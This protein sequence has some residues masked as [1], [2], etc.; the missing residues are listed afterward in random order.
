M[1]VAVT[2]GTTGADEATIGTSTIADGVQITT[3]ALLETP[4]AAIATC[5]EAEEIVRL[6]IGGVERVAHELDRLANALFQE[7]AVFRAV[8]RAH[9]SLHVVDTLQIEPLNHRSDR[10]H[11]QEV[12]AVVITIDDE[13]RHG[14]R[15]ADLAGVRRRL[16]RGGD[17]LTPEAARLAAV[18]HVHCPPGLTDLA[19]LE[20]SQ[21]PVLVLVLVLGQ[22]LGHAHALLRD[23]PVEEM[24]EVRLLEMR[25]D[26]VAREELQRQRRDAGETVHQPQIDESHADGSKDGPPSYRHAKLTIGALVRLKA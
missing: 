20:A 26:L 8:E 25:G 4:L 24:A 15:A 13:D 6:K 12:A 11:S 2:E 1:T 5:Q 14:G 21:T 9:Q 19:D 22:A 3:I 17:T 16:P 23:L 10:T 18:D 7:A